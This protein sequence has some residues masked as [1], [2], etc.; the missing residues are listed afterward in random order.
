MINQKHT[1]NKLPIEKQKGK[2][3]VQVDS[4]K[5]GEYPAHP[6]LYFAPLVFCW[7]LWCLLD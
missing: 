3:H 4:L 7:V 6:H 5:H 1:Q 2:A